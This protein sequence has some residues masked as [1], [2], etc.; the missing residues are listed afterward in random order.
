MTITNG[1][2]NSVTT[3]SATEYTVNVTAASPGVV[4]ATIPAGGVEDIA[5]NLNNAS[6]STDNA[7][8]YAP[9]DTTPP[10]DPVLPPDMT[11]PTDTGIS[12]TDDITSD[13]TPDFTVTCTEVGSTITLYIDGVA[14]G[15]TV[16]SAIGDTT[17]TP[18]TDI[19]E[20]PH[21]VTYTEKD[22]S[23]NESGESPILP[24]VI[25]VTDPSIPTVISQVTNDT[26]PTI[27]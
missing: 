21:D 3:V 16:C 19:P 13:Q 14:N 25:D 27:E 1:T 23:G 20:G 12:N 2:C 7:V 10:A 8:T 11:D 22:A 15:T 18:T 6:T 24:I 5:G 17:V 26:T 9:S 4:S